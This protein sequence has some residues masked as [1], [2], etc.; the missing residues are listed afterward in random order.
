VPAA[1]ISET[2]FQKTL[3]NTFTCDGGTAKMVEEQ[4][5][6]ARNHRRGIS[7]RGKADSDVTSR[8]ATK[9]CAVVLTGAGHGAKVGRAE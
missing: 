8:I 5:R 3:T 1:L 7:R 6:R 4:E 2:P 9:D